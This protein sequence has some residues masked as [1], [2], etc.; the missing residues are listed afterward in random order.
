MGLQFE[1]EIQIQTFISGAGITVDLYDPAGSPMSLNLNGMERR[2][3]TLNPRAGSSARIHV[4]N[5]DLPPMSGT[6]A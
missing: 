3:L 4:S 5:P 6:G 2:S 1:T